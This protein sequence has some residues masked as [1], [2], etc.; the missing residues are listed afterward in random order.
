VGEKFLEKWT[1]GWGHIITPYLPV[2]STSRVKKN[3]KN[4]IKVVDMGVL[5][6]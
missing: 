6:I 3:S 1:P 5:S 2:Q 4:A